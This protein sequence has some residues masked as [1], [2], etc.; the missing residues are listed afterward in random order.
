MRWVTVRPDD[1]D[2]RMRAVR[3]LAAIDRRDR[4]LEIG[5]DGVR[6]NARSPLAH[7]ILGMSL[8]AYGSTRP[9]LA[10]L[11]RAEQLFTKPRDRDR[12]RQLVASMRQGAPDSLREMFRADSV[13]HAGA[14]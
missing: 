10:E 13:E 1:D 6:H 12:V 3:N 14:K 4:A 2:L 11:R 7:M 5:R 9:A 8:E